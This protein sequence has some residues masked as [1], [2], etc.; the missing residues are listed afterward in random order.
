M[1]HTINKESEKNEEKMERSNL[2][3]YFNEEGQSR[4]NE[5]IND[6]ESN[7]IEPKDSNR[8]TPH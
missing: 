8:M 4:E 5:E 7:P 1:N 6:R 2:C 3:I